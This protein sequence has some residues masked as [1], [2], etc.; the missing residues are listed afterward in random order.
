VTTPGPPPRVL[1]VT[2][3]GRGIGAACALTAAA[4]G[5]DVGVNYQRDRAAAEGVAAKVRALGRRASVL[6][7]D[8]AD[9]D[10]VEAMFR[11]LD[12]ELGP[13]GGLVANAG[14]VAPAARVDEMNA[15]RITRV[16]AVNVVGAFLCAREAVR[17][18]STRH[19][20][21]GGAIVHLSSAAARLA[22]P[23][24][25]VDY[26]ASK[27]AVDNLTLGL[28]LEVAAEGIRV[29]GV[30][31]GIIDTEIHATSGMLERA[32]AQVAK[33]PLQ[34]M[35]HAD[36]IARAVVWLLSDDAG[37]VTGATLDVTGGR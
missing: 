28:A 35:G 29:N 6:Q 21:R 16:F 10:A 11:A 7:A 33:I 18:M 19:G 31:P 36:E 1:L 20:G 14:I 15:Q 27:A 17:R 13:L 24:I 22:S 30:R 8:V 34:R 5:W 32:Q 4:A 37:Y 3:A 12:A 25:Y 23:G 26:S 2:G 9:E